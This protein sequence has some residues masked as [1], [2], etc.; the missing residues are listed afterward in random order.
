MAHKMLV[1]RL[2]GWKGFQSVRHNKSHFG[3]SGMPRALISLVELRR[4]VDFLVGFFFF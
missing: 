4:V 1:I 2:G 3:A